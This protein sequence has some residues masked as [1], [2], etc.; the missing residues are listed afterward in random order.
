MWTRCSVSCGLGVTVRRRKCNKPTTEDNGQDCLGNDI[1]ISP[2]N[3]T[4][5]CTRK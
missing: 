4:V 1:E 2:C 3:E 5:T